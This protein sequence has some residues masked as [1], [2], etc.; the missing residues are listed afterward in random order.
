MPASP[1]STQPAPAPTPAPTP[2]SP[3]TA[4]SAP[5]TAPPPTDAPPP[6]FSGPAST[7]MFDDLEEFTKKQAAPGTEEPSPNDPPPEETPQPDEQPDEQPPPDDTDAKAGKGKEG[8]KRVNAWKKVDEY[9]K[10][11]VEL[12]R[13]LAEKSAQPDEQVRTQ[14]EALQKRNEELENHIRFV[15]YSKSKEFEEKH[16]KPYATAWKKAMGELGELTVS[17]ENGNVRPVTEQDLEALVSL[18]LSKAREWADEKFGRFADDA[19]QHR[20]EIKRLLDSQKEALAQARET[21]TNEIRQKEEL[22]SQESVQ[23]QKGV[24]EA[25]QASTKELLE[26]PQWGKFFQAVEGDE[27]HNK[28]LQ[29]G[30]EIADSALKANLLD[31]KLTPEE[32]KEKVRMLAAARLRTAAFGPTLYRLQKAEARA[33]ALEKEL[34]EYKNTTPKPTG[35][36]TAPDNQKKFARTSDELMADLDR[37][38][39]KQ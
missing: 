39:G 24:F 22:A 27:E 16:W 31:P 37:L 23:L 2:A 38:V 35:G 26:H 36:R 9:K 5:P 28:R 33:A 21:A 34:G 18:P 14:I 11:V 13:K 12:E 20:K 4:P 10:Q 30:F 15:D 32:R 3:P 19:M 7:R 17:D 1:S 8:K 6:K 25:F 29:R